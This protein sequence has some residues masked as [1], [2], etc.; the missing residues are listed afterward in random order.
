MTEVGAFQFVLHSHIPYARKAG[1]WP[2]GE[3]WLPRSSLRN[4]YP[5][6][7]GCFTNCGKKVFLIA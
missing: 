5:I 7:C 4:L 3:E 1:S 6:C 2:H